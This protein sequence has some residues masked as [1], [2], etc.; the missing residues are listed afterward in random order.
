MSV[1]P[2]KVFAVSAAGVTEPLFQG[3]RDYDMKVLEG[4]LRIEL[5]RSGVA[6]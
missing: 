3:K 6:E 1:P 4:S 5:K 2:W